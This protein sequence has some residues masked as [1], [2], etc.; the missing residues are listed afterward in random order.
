VGPQFTNDQYSLAIAKRHPDFARFVNAVLAKMRANGQL[1][2]LD[3]HTGPAPP[4][5]R[6][7]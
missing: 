7:R 4:R 5:A 1:C 3:R 2:P 6:Y